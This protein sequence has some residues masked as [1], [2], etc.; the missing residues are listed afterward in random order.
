MSASFSVVS[1]QLAM[2]PWAMLLLV[3]QAWLKLVL[4]LLK[5]A[6]HCKPVACPLLLLK[7]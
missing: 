6:L 1:V 2:L 4:V 5:L 7:P 3:Q